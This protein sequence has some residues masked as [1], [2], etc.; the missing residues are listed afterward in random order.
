LARTLLQPAKEPDVFTPEHPNYDS[1]L[2]SALNWYNIERDKRDARGY[3]RNYVIASQGRE[4]LKVFDRIPDKHIK[5]T[6]G[7]LSRLWVNGARFT[8]SHQQ[9]LDDYVTNLLQVELP[10]EK[11]KTEV[12]K[13]SVRDYVKEKVQTFLGEM[14]GIYDDVLFK[15]LEHDLFK[16]LQ[17][18][19]FPATSSGELKDWVTTKLNLLISITETDDP[20]I[21]EGYANITKRKH[22]FTLKVLNQ[23]LEDIDKY[24]GFKKA[25]RKPRAKKVKSP[26]QQVAKLKY[27][28]E[29]TELNIKSVLPTEIVGA[30]QVWIYNTKY[31][32]LAVYRTDSMTGIQIK[33]SSLQNYDP[34]LC[35]QKTLRKPKETLHSVISGGKVQL[36]RILDGLTTKDTPVNGRINDECL[37]I[38]ALK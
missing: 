19:T 17:T 20:L 27:K 11:P 18:V 8:P 2:G 22:T 10:V 6:F 14:E 13:P 3:V 38:R 26:Q 33:G 35:E 5:T 21:I 1:I 30:L 23:W 31:K 28:K 9:Q 32:K 36:R 34:E 29:D 4:P 12:T 15:S 16:N 24:T 37:I 25:N 7:W